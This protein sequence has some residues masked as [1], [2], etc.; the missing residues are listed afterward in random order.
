ML[1]QG[2]MRGVPSLR[3]SIYD[4]P[5]AA[6]RRALKKRVTYYRLVNPINCCVVSLCCVQGTAQLPVTFGAAVWWGRGRIL[7]ERR[8]LDAA[9]REMAVSN[10]LLWARS[11]ATP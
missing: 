2:R 6:A 10:L 1:P 3:P 8:I 9:S 11:T 7:P 4:S 5:R